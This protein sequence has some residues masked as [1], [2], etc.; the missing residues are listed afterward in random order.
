MR[1]ACLHSRIRESDGR[2][3]TVAT[4]NATPS[5]VLGEWSLRA[6]IQPYRASPLDR[7][8]HYLLKFRDFTL[9]AAP[10]HIRALRPGDLSAYL[11]C[12]PMRCVFTL[13]GVSVFFFPTIQKHRDHKALRVRSPAIGETLA[14]SE[15]APPTLII[16]DPLVFLIR[17]VAS[18]L[19]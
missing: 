11:L 2:W 15:V 1:P 3:P 9:A 4:H 6:D 18:G 17:R 16:I 14:E 7:M 5:Y 13:P 8:M 19:N 12:V 10:L